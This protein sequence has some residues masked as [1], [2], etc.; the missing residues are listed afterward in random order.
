MTDEID[1]LVN[2][3][4]SLSFVHDDRLVGAFEGDEQRITRASHV[5]PLKGGW[6]ADMRPSGG[7]IL[8]VEGEWDSDD[9]YP[10]PRTLAD[11]EADP[12]RLLL[13]PFRTRQEALNAERQW[14]RR[15]RGL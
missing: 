9:L 11:F 5:E 12:H 15:E 14:L 6:V 4:G 8:F 13:T 2:E 7:G 10:Q 3:D 1:I